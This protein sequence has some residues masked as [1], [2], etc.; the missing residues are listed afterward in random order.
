MKIDDARLMFYPDNKIFTY[1][2]DRDYAREELVFNVTEDILI[3][4]ETLEISKV[5]LAKK[6][7][8]SKSYVTQVLSGTRNMTLGT[9]SDICFSLHIKPIVKIE[10]PQKEE[11]FKN[12]HFIKIVC[13]K[14]KKP[15][16]HVREIDVNTRP[17][18]VWKD[19]PDTGFKEAC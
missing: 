4:M 5:E 9:L 18:K 13:D 19:F 2:E 7:S 11:I 16:N 1:E 6:L 14:E 3:A 8:K 12:S 10:I 15:L 17:T